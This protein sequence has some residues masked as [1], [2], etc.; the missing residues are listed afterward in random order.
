MNECGV[1]LQENLI[2]QVLFNLIKNAIDHSPENET[3]TIEALKSDQKLK[4]TIEN[5]GEFINDEQ[6]HKLFEPFY[7]TRS[8]SE[9]RGLGI[10]LTIVHSAVKLMHG[11]L[12]LKNKDNGGLIIELIIPLNYYN[13]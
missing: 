5:E 13:N 2:R 1:T 12:K 6:L 7:S 4:V 8:D 3:I 9:Y 10:G 11:E